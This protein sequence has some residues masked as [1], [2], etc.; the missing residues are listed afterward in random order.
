[1]IPFRTLLR[2]QGRGYLPDKPDARDFA[3]KDLLGAIAEPLPAFASVRHPDVKPKDQGG[4]ES[5]TAQ[6]TAQGFRTVEL[7]QGGTCPDLSALFNYYAGRAEWGGQNLDA[8]SFLRTAIKAAIKFG[9]APETEWP[10]RELAV[11][12]QPTWNAF[13]AAHDLRG[14]HGYHRCD[15]GDADEVRRAIAQGYPVV[16]GWLVDSAF[17]QSSGPTVIDVITGAPVG[18]HA[19]LVDEYFSDG[20]FAILNSWSTNWRAQGRARITEAFVRRGIDLWAIG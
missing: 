17:C 7:H 9:F 6:A 11:N 5:C 3:A 19:L 20:T 1:M 13:R 15:P 16:G 10:F 8:G 12:K 18:G 4:T 14:P 2:R